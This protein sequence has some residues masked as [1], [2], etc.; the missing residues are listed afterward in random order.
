MDVIEQ[1]TIALWPEFYC[2]PVW[3][4]LAGNVTANLLN[5][6]QPFIFLAIV[7]TELYLLRSNSS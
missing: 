4:F 3:K 5:G 1:V 6:V 2:R 7:A